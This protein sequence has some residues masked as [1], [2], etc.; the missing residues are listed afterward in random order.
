[1]STAAPVRPQQRRAVEAPGSLLTRHRPS[2]R[3]T[4]LLAVLVVGVVGGIALQGRDTLEV[5]RSDL[6]PFQAATN[7][8]RDSLDASRGSS[9]LLNVLDGIANALNAVVQAL[10]HLLS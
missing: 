3:T 1:M 4:A 8:L 6:S 7:G 10:Q 5:A 9:V 2:T